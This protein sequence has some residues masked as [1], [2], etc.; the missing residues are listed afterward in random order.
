MALLL[1]DIAFALVSR[2]VPQMNVFAVG[3]PA[4]V[5]IGFA[6][7][8]ASLPFVAGH[9]EDQLQAFV[10]QALLAFKA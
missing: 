7:V 3:L 1:T 10:L 4:K 8:A 5:L 9:L 6:T 2:A